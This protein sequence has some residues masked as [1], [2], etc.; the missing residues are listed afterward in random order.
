MLY[1]QLLEV[2]LLAKLRDE[3]KFASLNEL[4]TQISCDVQQALTMI[5][6]HNHLTSTLNSNG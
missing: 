2:V 4:T 6:Q 1:G 3:Q 5:E